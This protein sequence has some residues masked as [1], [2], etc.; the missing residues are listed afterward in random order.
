MSVS[1]LSRSYS[2]FHMNF[3]LYRMW[4]I[5]THSEIINL[6]SF[7]TSDWFSGTQKKKQNPA[8]RTQPLQKTL[9]FKIQLKSLQK[10]VMQR[11]DVKT[12][13]KK[14]IHWLL[15]HLLTLCFFPKTKYAIHILCPSTFTFHI[16]FHIS[17]ELGKKII[18][19]A[20]R[21]QNRVQHHLTDQKGDS[22]P[23]C[24]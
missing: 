6:V 13:H 17:R 9:Q 16:W 5:A 14:K 21:I 4:N 23:K 22:L 11:D 18:F 20:Y 19:R 8:M 3:Y 1:L 2:L 24:K 7:I 12:E 10:C 15:S